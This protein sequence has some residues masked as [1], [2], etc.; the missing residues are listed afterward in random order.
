MQSFS[1]FIVYYLLDSEVDHQI[2]NIE[3]KFSL[4]SFIINLITF[5]WISFHSK[6]F[7]DQILSQE[8][9]EI[10]LTLFKIVPTLYKLT[11]RVSLYTQ[12]QP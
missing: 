3:S 1:K 10:S 5:D 7:S 12:H 8:V 4:K 11:S 9:F 2:K 6:S